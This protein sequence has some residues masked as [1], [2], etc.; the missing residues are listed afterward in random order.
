[1][2]EFQKIPKMP[3]ETAD[4][5]SEGA[6]VVESPAPDE[7]SSNTD[8][9]SITNDAKTEEADSKTD[10][11]KDKLESDKQDI[12]QS[13]DISNLDSAVF[14]S[15]RL[16]VISDDAES[17]SDDSKYIIAN[18]QNIYLIQYETVEDAMVA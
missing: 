7:I 17:I 3:D 13:Y 9:D 1:M 8:E 15:A 4:T 14:S 10:D 18:Y 16:V 5:T 11:T 12:E 6:K 2:M